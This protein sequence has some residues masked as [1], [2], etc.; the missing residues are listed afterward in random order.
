MNHTILHVQSGH[1]FLGS[2]SRDDSNRATFAK[3]VL[4]LESESTRKFR[5]GEILNNRVVP[6]YRKFKPIYVVVEYESTL[7]GRVDRQVVA[8]TRI[9]KRSD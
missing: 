4:K 3:K 2:P 1:N 8:I 7:H 9:A 6:I 5:Q